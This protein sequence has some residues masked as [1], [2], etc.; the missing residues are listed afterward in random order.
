MHVIVVIIIIML[1]QKLCIQQNSVQGS[2]AW[3]AHSHEVTSQPN[4]C[5]NWGKGLERWCYNNLV[6]I[7]PR[8]GP[9]YV[10]KVQKTY[11]YN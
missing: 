1:H 4:Y 10:T 8:W 9:D 6:T 7:L 2:V 5:F 11:K 3:I